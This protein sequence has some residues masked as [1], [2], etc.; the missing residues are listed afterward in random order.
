MLKPRRNSLQIFILATLYHNNFK[1]E[2]R[3]YKYLAPLGFTQI[4]SKKC[5][6]NL[7]LFAAFCQSVDS[8]ASYYCKKVSFSLTLSFFLFFLLC[9]RGINVLLC[10]VRTTSTVL[11]CTNLICV[12][13][14]TQFEL[15]N[16]KSFSRIGYRSSTKE[17]HFS[18][19]CMF[20]ALRRFSSNYA[21]QSI[22]D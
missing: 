19:S 12:C 14:N 8:M 11:L 13:S 1:T 9:P 22:S 15:F 18:N 3:I 21:Q 7:I 16:G 6:P 5:K 20:Y 17:S 4:F 2:Y 10:E